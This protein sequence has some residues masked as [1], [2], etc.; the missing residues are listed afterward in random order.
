MTSVPWRRLPGTHIRRFPRRR[1][2][3]DDGEDSRR[4]GDSSGDQSGADRT[5]R[6][7]HRGRPDTR[8]RH[9]SGRRRPGLAVVRQRQTPRLRRSRDQLDP[10][11]PTGQHHSGRARSRGRRAQR[12]PCVHWL[13]GAAAAAQASRHRGDPGARRRQQGHRRSAPDQP[14]A[15]G[16]EREQGDHLVSA[17]HPPRDHRA[18]DASR[19]RTG[20]T[21][22]RH[23]GA[24]RDCRAVAAAAADPPGRERDRDADPHRHRRSE[25]PPAQ[26]GRDRRGRGRPR[27]RHRGR[28]ETGGRRSRRRG[29][30]GAG[31]GEPEVADRRRRRP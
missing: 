13:P 23:R 12:R 14:G 16:T 11:R 10:A 19:Y 6:Q 31:P 7:A 4:Q 17:V 22:R 18:D 1:W 26:G 21:G 25:R 5:G 30:P 8:A 15:A 3:E 28:C 20:R 29:Q 24:R 9:G 2:R 27:D